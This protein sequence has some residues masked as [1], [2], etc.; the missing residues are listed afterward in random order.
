MYSEAPIIE[1]INAWTSPLFVTTNPD[2]DFLKEDLLSYIYKDQ[3]SQEAPIASQV[4]VTAKHQL[5]ESK[6]NFL[7][8]ENAAVMEVRRLFEEV[9]SAIATEVN[10][11][12]WPEESEGD[13]TIIESWY[14]VTKNGGYHDIHSHP[15]CSWC[16]IYYLEPGECELGSRNGVNRF[17][18]PRI[19]A[20]HYSDVG[21]AY[22]GEHG[23]WD[24]EPVE[25]QLVIFPSYLKHSALPYFG[26]ADRI[27]IAFNSVIDFS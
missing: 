8:A 2:H 22:L 27:V 3:E 6:L 10:A 18:D 12:Y 7:E 23:F 5:F 20:D 17:Y 4:A 26:E 15:N 24:F 21:T 11:P 19:N 25:G 13:A 1:P 16:G 9:V 14:H